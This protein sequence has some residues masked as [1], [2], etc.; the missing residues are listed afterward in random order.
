MKMD[1]ILL[2][3]N[4]KMTSKQ[5]KLE[6]LIDN[7]H[8]LFGYIWGNIDFQKNYVAIIDLNLQNGLYIDLP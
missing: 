4:I 7:F 5:G 2:K 1:K 8:A 6:D 3:S